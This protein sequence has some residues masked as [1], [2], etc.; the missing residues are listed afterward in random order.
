M[1]KIKDIGESADAEIPVAVEV[2]TSKPVDDLYEDTLKS[3]GLHS[4]VQKMGPVANNQINGPMDIEEMDVGKNIINNSTL[5]KG[6]FVK[7][8]H[9]C[10]INQLSETKERRQAGIK[11]DEP[12]GKNV[13]VEQLCNRG[14]VFLSKEWIS[15]TLRLFFFVTNKSKFGIDVST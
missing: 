10:M 5:S 9:D 7:L 14:K 2:V 1:T 12:A 15:N 6:N 13:A 11:E 3:D 4:L 8:S